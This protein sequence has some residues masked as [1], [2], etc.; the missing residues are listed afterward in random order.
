[1]VLTTG[2]AFAAVTTHDSGSFG[3]LVAGHVDFGVERAV[4]V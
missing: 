3:V 2:A 4:D 1:M